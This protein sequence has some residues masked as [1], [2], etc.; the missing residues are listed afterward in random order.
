MVRSAGL[1][2]GA[3]AVRNLGP[4]VLV[5]FLA[6]VFDQETVGHY[7]L[8]L[9]VATPIFALAQMG[10]RTVYV[11]LRPNAPIRDYVV[12]QGLAVAVAF[13]VL[14]VIAGVAGAIGLTL[15]VVGVSRV[16]DTFT[17]MLTGPL[18]LAGRIGRIFAA[19]VAIAGLSVAVTVVVM[20]T[21]HNL[22][23]SLTGMAGAAVAATFV[24]MYL[25]VR[26]VGV[27]TG[28]WSQGSATRRTVLAAGLPTGVAV[29][30][31]SL[32]ST[33]PQYF[34]T[35]W[36]GSAAAA[37]AQVLFY[38]YFA[39]DLATLGVVQAWIPHARRRLADGALAPA[40]VRTALRWTLVYVLVAVVGLALAAWLLPVV[41]G[42]GYT[43]GLAQ[44]VPLGLAIG[45]LPFASFSMV[46][47]SVLNRYTH[48]LTLGASSTLAALV[49]YAVLIGPFAVTGA[50]WGLVGAVATRAVVGLLIVVTDRGR[51]AAAPA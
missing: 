7:T 19:A 2:F 9:A 44:A 47:V 16:A 21:T 48:N 4:L 38:L 49:L 51:N 22:D 31:L 8:A 6:R 10:L 12:V 37:H 32:V 40:L 42:A 11:T 34:L 24:F 15:L 20:L 35:P 30:V 45:L 43:L 3:S 36:H 39:A 41:F 13:A 27:S 5:V 18:Q 26:A 23:W 28:L 29:A 17:E 46:S 14:A 33:M 50:A 1:L 25:P